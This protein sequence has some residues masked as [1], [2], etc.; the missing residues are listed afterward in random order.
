VKYVQER[1]LLDLSEEEA[2]ARFSQLISESMISFSTQLNFFVHNLAQLKFGK[3]GTSDHSL[4]FIPNKYSMA[5]DG[6]IK[7]VVVHGIQ[8]R[9]DT[10]KH[11]LFILKLTRHGIKDPVY[12]FRTY[13]QFCEF[14]SRLCTEY[15]LTK[16]HSIPSGY[17]LGR[18]NIRE[19]AERR[20]R[21]I[22]TF[23]SSLFLLAEEISHSDL[24]YTFFHPLLKDEEET[25]IHIHKLKETRGHVRKPSV[26][27]IRGRMKLKIYYR[28]ETLHVLIQ[29][30]ENLSVN[31]AREEP[32]SY[33]KVYLHPDPNKLTKRKTKV[34]RRSCNPTFMEMLE[35]RTPL[36]IVRCRTLQATVWDSSQFQENM[37]LG[38]VTVPLDDPALS[39]NEGIEQWFSLELENQ[40]V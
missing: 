21:E 23:L 38:C 29:F 2:S 35:Y 10:E 30:V 16:F 34:V 5:S 7:D 39:T 24:V 4:S 33:V 17:S 25:N 32:N 14:H 31:D 1:L 6:K 28:N 19:V 8:K 12:V 40:N 11:Y 9:Y 18:S 37:F 13:K 36:D 20:K 27:K 15:P 22:G 26:G 3:G